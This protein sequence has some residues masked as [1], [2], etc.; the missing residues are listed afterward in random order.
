MS[1][2]SNKARAQLQTVP[3]FV[4][5]VERPRVPPRSFKPV[6]SLDVKSAGRSVSSRVVKD[7]KIPRPPAPKKV[8]HLSK[9]AFDELMAEFRQN[10]F[11]GIGATVYNGTLSKIHWN[12]EGERYEAWSN[13][14]FRLF[15]SLTEVTKNGTTYSYMLMASGYDHDFFD[16]TKPFPAPEHPTLPETEAAYVVTSG[17][18][19]NDKALEIITALHEIYLGQKEELQVAREK[20][21]KY[22]REANAW[23]KANPPQPK[24]INVS[25]WRR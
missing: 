17:N 24:D 10:V 6:R 1:E 20:R 21:M 12:Y 8:T 15:Q 18:A 2:S 13:I 9:E 4:P 5:P 19:E 3:D 7:P 11:V 16:K 25:F 23:R 22:A 14:D